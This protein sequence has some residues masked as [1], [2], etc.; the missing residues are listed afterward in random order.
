MALSPTLT[1]V[2]GLGRCRSFYARLL[3]SESSWLGC[4]G[5]RVPRRGRR[6]V[7]RGTS[8]A[9]GPGRDHLCEGSSA[10]NA[11]R[12][13]GPAAALST[14]TRRSSDRIRTSSS[15]RSN[16][17]ARTTH[18]T[19][20]APRRT[21]VV[22]DGEATKAMSRT[23]ARCRASNVRVFVSIVFCPAEAHSSAF[24]HPMALECMCT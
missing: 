4:T 2:D 12:C 19:G 8:A 15:T 17:L 16:L 6:V 11:G 18:R 20:S 10:R 13:E 9:A 23:P 14:G 1:P 21:T 22:G 3:P 5:H 7:Q 24:R